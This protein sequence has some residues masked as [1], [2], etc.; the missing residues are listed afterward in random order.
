M[1]FAAFD[2]M[3]ERTV[4]L[5]LVT[6]ADAAR[7]AVREARALAKLRHPNVVAVHD[8]GLHDDVAYLAMDLVPD[9]DLATW[10]TTP[11]SWRAIVASVLAI[12]RGLVAAHEL[13]IVHGD[14][15]PANVLVDGDRFVVSDFGIARAL[16]E[17]GGAV[18]GT[19]AYMAPEQREGLAADP[20]SDQYSLC[21]LAMRA[22]TG[23]STAKPTD[24]DA[25]T[26]SGDSNTDSQPVVM[27]HRTPTGS[28]WRG[29]A[30]RRVLAVLRRGLSRDPDQRWPSVQALIDAL[31]AASSR[32]RLPASLA[33]IGL[34][35]AAVGT[36]VAS[37]QQSPARCQAV[38][39]PE[40][41]G[42]RSVAKSA[43]LDSGAPEADRTWK[44]VSETLDGYASALGDARSQAC[45]TEEERTPEVAELSRSCLARAGF[46]LQ[47]VGRKLSNVD[48]ASVHHA[49]R[50]PDVL[51]ELEECLDVTALRN[52]PV[53]PRELEARADS[54]R[55]KLVEVRLHLAAGEVPAA[56]AM[57]RA[58]DL[59]V[60]EGLP[61]LSVERS[62]VH[63]R[64]LRRA[65]TY[66]AAV[67][68]LEAALELALAHD[69]PQRGY[70]AARDLAVTLGAHLGREPEARAMQRVARSLAV[71]GG[72]DPDDLSALEHNW[73]SVMLRSGDWLEAAKRSESALDHYAS[74]TKPDELRIAT[75]V[76]DLATAWRNIG[77]LEQAL[78]AAERALSMRRDI[79]G[80]GHPL[81]AR[82]EDRVAVVLGRQGEY[83][84]SIEHARTAVSALEAALGS[85]HSETLAVRLNLAT[86]LGRIDARSEA[87]AELR[88]LREHALA[89][90]DRTPTIKRVSAAAAVN[91]ANLLAT[92][93][94]AEEAAAL[95][96][97]GL[98]QAEALWGE[99]HPTV[100]SARGGLA[101]A[102]ASIGDYVEAEQEFRAV[103]EMLE[104]RLGTEHLDVSYPLCGLADVLALTGKQAEA[105]KTA[106]RCLAIRMSAEAAADLRAEAQFKLARLIGPH[107]EARL[108][109][110]DALVG[111][112]AKGHA[113]L[114]AEVRA[115][116]AA[117]TDRP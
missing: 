2:P 19:P 113:K 21:L 54:L 63:A 59:E 69:L 7:A 39:A 60:P 35:V 49:H 105:T 41:S 106:R 109:A 47:A 99:E 80:P 4:A 45:R 86:T 98:D 43:V 79:L 102:L 73:A 29:R 71:R 33:A 22:L 88:T 117:P 65:G 24:A 18:A 76:E 55:A 37:Q 11:R 8:G 6:R 108:L 51:P 84:A 10:L 110:A 31:V 28:R 104:A 5:K 91:L 94:R 74:V 3:L 101:G 17:V 92:S 56:V 100:L 13:G 44:N 103:I 112:E 61:R 27:P 52:E 115:W 25:R 46:R 81:T 68:V 34:S 116:L 83:E 9:G 78:G 95:Y 62:L 64:V 32:R 87:E 23:E 38:T 114:A 1:V 20:L 14:V 67:P 40:W 85:R 26:R 111:F 70:E 48:A 58:L 89:V 53:V 12:G 16:G 50:L 57:D 96:R 77:K 72:S 66:E 75:M 82:S 107:D 30:P 97:E 42:T 36:A 15:K 90:R 93:D